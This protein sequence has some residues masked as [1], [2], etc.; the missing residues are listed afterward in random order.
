MDGPSPETPF[1]FDFHSDSNKNA[2]Y[3]SSHCSAPDSFHYLAEEE[4]LNQ[5]Y[6]W[7]GAPKK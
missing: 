7:N 1:L 5:I 3:A 4:E 2:C 6:E